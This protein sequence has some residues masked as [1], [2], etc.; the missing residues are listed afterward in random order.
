MRFARQDFFA[1]LGSSARWLVVFAG[2]PFL[3]IPL[4][5]LAGILF[6]L[7]SLWWRQRN[8][9]P[10]RLAQA[11][12]D[13]LLCRARAMFAFSNVIDLFVNELAS[14]CTRRFPFLKVFLCTLKRLLFR[15]G[16]VSSP[17]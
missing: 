2:L 14:G 11:N 5:T 15:H 6:H 1:C 12:G 8:S 4:R 16:L 17:H 3:K 7:A 10:P 13:R 9:S